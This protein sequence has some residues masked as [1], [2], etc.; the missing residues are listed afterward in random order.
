MPYRLAVI[1]VTLAGCANAGIKGQ[2]DDDQVDAPRLDAPMA[3]APCVPVTTEVLVNGSFDSMPEG[4]GW[5]Q[6]PIDP[7]LPPITGDEPVPAI[8]EQS[9]TLKAWMGGFA[10]AAADDSISQP[11]AIP[12]GTTALM[13][14]GYYW[15]KSADS[16][17]VVH[18]TSTVELVGTGSTVI[19]TALALDNK[20]RHTTWQPLAHDIPVGTLA[21]TTVTFRISSHNDGTSATS[22]WYDTLSLQATHCP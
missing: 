3:D 16:T 2:G 22:F 9:P 19:D 21:G 14:T 11:L 6:V 12:P 18:D 10:Q 7:T 17:T 13:L 1:A 4:T 15:V 20:T 8:D 5:T